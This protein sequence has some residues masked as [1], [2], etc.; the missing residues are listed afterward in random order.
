MC[1]TKILFNPG[2][3]IDRVLSN[4]LYDIQLSV[5]YFI[6]ILKTTFAKF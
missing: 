5:T 2:K 6:H 4:I 1:S 3:K